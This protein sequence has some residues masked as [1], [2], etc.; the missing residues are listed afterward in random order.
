M[1]NAGARPDRTLCVFYFGA[2]PMPTLRPSHARPLVT[3]G[4]ETRPISSHLAH[5]V[6]RRGERRAKRVRSTAKLC[7]FTGSPYFR[8]EPLVA[9]RAEASGRRRHVSVA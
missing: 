5:D 4:S 8:R 1:Q 7:G 9:Y 6:E 2:R 3:A